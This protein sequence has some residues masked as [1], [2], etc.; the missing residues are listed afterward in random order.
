MTGAEMRPTIS[1]IVTAREENPEVLAATIDALLA[2]SEGH[3]R[4]IVLIDDGSA[5]PVAIDRPQVRMVRNEAPIGV[6]RSRR[7]G[8]EMSSGPILGFCDAHMS[9]APDW[10]DHML[11]WV[12]TGALLCA[13]W[14]NYELSRPLC[15]GSDFAWCGER[16]YK[17]GRSP[18]FV[19]RHRTR[20]PG[21][22]APEVPMALGA[23]YVVLRDSYD[24]AGGFCPFFRTW[25]KSEQDIS[26]R[27]WISGAG[28]RC[29]TAAHAG[30]WSRKKF[31][32]PVRWSD[33]EF[34]QA[35][36]LRAIFEEPTCRIFEEL[37]RPLPADV[38]DWLA[39]TDLGPW[40]ASIQSRRRMS[41]SEFVERFAPDVDARVVAA[42]RR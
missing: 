30:H 21:E 4:E 18:G 7:L 22:G 32:Y 11:A 37:L 35:V 16:D 33:I 5:S 25:G 39:G 34:N 12:D 9:F 3:E 26:T 42:L 15:W 31:P 27:M 38:E 6:A 17:A 20:Y 24:R 29:V 28:V 36:M 10:L 2:T 23:C 13:A 40:R 14:W 19:V 8:A 41:D 1:F